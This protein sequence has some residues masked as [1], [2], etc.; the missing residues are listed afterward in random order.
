MES[1]TPLTRCKTCNTVF[2]VPQAI[3]DSVDSR[4][5]CGECLQVF[6]AREHLHEVEQLDLTAMVEPNDQLAAGYQ[7]STI[8]P[9]NAEEPQFPAL[10]APDYYDNKADL[11]AGGADIDLLGPDA[12]LPLSSFEDN[13]TDALQLDFDVVD[14]AADEALSHTAD[15]G[16]EGYSLD[17]PAST[18]TRG[19]D[20]D[21]DTDAT[22]DGT[23]SIDPDDSSSDRHSIRR[24]NAIFPGTDKRNFSLDDS[25]GPSLVE[26]DF[27]DADGNATIVHP[28]KALPAVSDDGNSHLDST[29]D[30]TS[31]NYAADGDAK[32]D[33]SADPDLADRIALDDAHDH[34][35]DDTQHGS[36]ESADGAGAHLRAGDV[37]VRPGLATELAGQA[38][39]EELQKQ[40]DETVSQRRKGRLARWSLRALLSLCVFAIVSALYAYSH[41]DRLADKPLLRP[42]YK[43]WCLASGCSVPARLDT[44]KLLVVDKK[45]F[46]H[47]HIESALAITIVLR[48][49][50]DFEQRYP[51]LF[52]WL[53]DS[54]RRTVAS[55]EFEPNL[56]LQRNNLAP[57]S[58]LRPGEQQRISL[59]VLDPGDSAVSLELSFR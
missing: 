6:D 53:S 1:S 7:S 29:L 12:D 23:N 47:P 27:R 32:T 14:A 50:A 24:N 16:D 51:V 4:V 39:Q 31:L 25:D 20:R 41:R 13:T 34:A 44:T 42:G 28:I 54:A 52:M 55:N 37:S 2:E 11:S 8:D 48:N 10:P 49:T 59:D 35:L 58:V 57:D 43:L 19:S 56:Y 5:R 9:E 36:G 3:L 22:S 38:K 18:H 46:S 33:L 45:I 21:V 15:A 17:A 26:F 40:A 30:S